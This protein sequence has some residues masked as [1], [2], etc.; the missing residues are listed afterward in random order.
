[1]HSDLATI[2]QVTSFDDQR[3][4]E[5]RWFVG[6]EDDA[7]LSRRISY[8]ERGGLSREIHADIGELGRFETVIDRRTGL[9]RFAPSFR[10]CFR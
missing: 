7:V 3:A 6:A 5:T 2:T 10:A 8:E 9:Y 1:M 4:Q